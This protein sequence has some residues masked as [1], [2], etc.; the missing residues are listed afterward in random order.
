M[1][2]KVYYFN[3]H[4]G[5]PNIPCIFTECLFRPDSETLTLHV[6]PGIDGQ[7]HADHCME[8]N[9]HHPRCHGRHHHPI[10]NECPG[11]EGT[12]WS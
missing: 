4:T 6:H 5:K 10:L 7:A 11:S 8:D 3:L 9:R 2:Y 12:A 1:G